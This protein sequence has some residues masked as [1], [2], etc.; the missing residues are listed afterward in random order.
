MI[1]MGEFVHTILGKQCGV[2]LSKRG[3]NDNHVIFTI[4]SED[5]GNWFTSEHGRSTYWLKDLQDVLAETQAWLK[6]HTTET[7][8]GFELK[9][10]RWQ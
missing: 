8:W 6:S 3:P 9:E 1:A 7:P 5:D 2:G 4:L 10:T